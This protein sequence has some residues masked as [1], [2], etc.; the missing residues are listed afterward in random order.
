MT[1]ELRAIREHLEKM[2]EREAMRL[3]RI[4]RR[5]QEHGGSAELV[6]DIRN[7]GR[8]LRN[9]S[10]EY[11]LNPYRQSFQYAFRGYEKQKEEPGYF[12]IYLT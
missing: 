8:E 7:E 10:A 4:A 11:L 5:L 9:M 2:A 1:R 3:F 6:Q 12:Y